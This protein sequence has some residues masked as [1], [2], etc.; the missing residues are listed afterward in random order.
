MDTIVCTGPTCPLC[1]FPIL[2]I[3]LPRY[4]EEEAWKI[5]DRI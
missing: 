5:F 3:D 2:A 1:L 4:I